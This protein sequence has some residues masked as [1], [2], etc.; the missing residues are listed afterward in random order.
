MKAILKINDKEIEIEI[1]EKELK[2]LE[3]KK[4]PRKRW[5]AKK[6]KKYWRIYGDG[7]IADVREIND[8]YADYNYSIGNYFKTIEEAEFHKN[9][10]IYTQML[11]DYIYEHDDVELDWNNMSQDKYYLLYNFCNEEIDYYAGTG[12]TFKIQ[13]TIYTSNLQVL[14]DAVKFIGEENVKK[15]ILKV[16]E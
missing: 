1:T 8:I 10:L 15:Y 4:L 11:K 3:E 6:G 12:W 7:E 16:E 14:K 9:E 2:K 5:R 13:G